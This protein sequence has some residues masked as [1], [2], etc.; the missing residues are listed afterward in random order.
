MNTFIDSFMTLN[1]KKKPL[2]SINRILKAAMDAADPIRVIE[3]SIK[4]DE[5]RLQAGNKTFLLYPDSRI[6]VIAIGK[7]CLDMSSGAFNI[8]GNRISGGVA[9]CKHN[10]EKIGRIG[11]MD[12]ITGSHPVPDQSSINAAIQIKK[13]LSSVKDRDV[14]LLLISGGGSALVCLP[15]PN[16]DIED[17]QAVTGA[18]LKSGASINELNAV[19]KHLD[20]I[21]GGGLLKMAA[22]AQV[23]A[24]VISDVVNDPLDVI[25]SGPAVPDPTSFSDAKTVLE[26]YIGLQDVPCS[27]IKRIEAG[28]RNEIEDTLKPE[29]PLASFAEHTIIA[30]NK[31]SAQAACEQAFREGFES[32]IIT[33]DLVGEA[34]TAGGYLAGLVKRKNPSKR[35][36]IGIAGGETTVVVKGKGL[37]G[38]NL[39]VALGAVKDL[40]GLENCMLITLATDGEDGPTDAAGAYVTGQTLSTAKNLGLDP[41]VYLDNND[42]YHFF[43]KAGGLINTGPTGTNVNDLSFII[44]LPED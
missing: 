24:L 17:M 5:K 34:R 36:Y 40:D 3:R 30:S 29:D 4:L 20:L 35:P 26:K 28:C 14:V 21:K 6:I 43:E 41:D 9:V 18:L 19:R 38:R 7:A 39:E 12:V 44:R 2:Q 27:I 1:D 25:A 22:P 10:P 13:I 11:N 33:Y 16:I 31:L 42:A 8:L 15:A 32:E 37:G 23:G